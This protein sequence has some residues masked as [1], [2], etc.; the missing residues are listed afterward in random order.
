MSR[1]SKDY[2]N[3]TIY[4]IRNHI[5]DDINV[6]STTQSLSRRM[7][8]HRQDAKY[9]KSRTFFESSSLILFCLNFFNSSV[10]LFKNIIR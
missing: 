9:K 4:C 10:N 3:G 2:Q 5:D 6:G 1:I 8:C 7:A